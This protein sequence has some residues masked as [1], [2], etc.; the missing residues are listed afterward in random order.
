MTSLKGPCLVLAMFLLLPWLLLAQAGAPATQTISAAQGGTVKAPSGKATLTVPAGALAADTQVSIRELPQEAG[1]AIAPVYDIQPDGLEFSKPAT[2]T[3]QFAAGDL[4]EGYAAEDVMISEAVPAEDAEAAPAT[5]PP[6]PAGGGATIPPAGLGGGALP[7]G[8][9]GGGG[10]PGGGL[11]GAMG[12]AG[13][14][15]EAV[16]TIFRETVVDVAAGTASAQLEHLSRYTLRAVA[17]HELG[18]R[19]NLCEGVVKLFDLTYDDDSVTGTGNATAGCAVTGEMLV[20]A[21]VSVGEDGT[22]FAQC[23]GTKLFRVKPD[24]VGTR[25]VN[26]AWVQVQLDH[27]GDIGAGSNS[28]NIA[29]CVSFGE[30]LPEDVTRGWMGTP[31]YDNMAAA[32]GGQYLAPTEP[33]GSSPGVQAMKGMFRKSF[34]RHPVFNL[35]AMGPPYRQARPLVHFGECRL[36]AGHV[37]GV[38]ISLMAV[39]MGQTPDS[40]GGAAGGSVDFTRPGQFMV[41][42]IEV[43]SQ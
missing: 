36:R 17:G 11:G 38:Q 3:I 28:Y 33:G 18:T 29:Y 39:V 10:L 9:L 13:A 41:T 4:P 5:T 8:G 25:E 19:Q 21:E 15:Q 1:L 6:T 20:R 35:P 40:Y 27:A 32:A 2:L 43:Y 26:T 22:A 30:W 23:I 16:D 31:S 42:F 37:Y 24:V 7:G 34:W 14:G 12:A